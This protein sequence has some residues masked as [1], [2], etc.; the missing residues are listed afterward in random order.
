MICGLL[1]I[2]SNW[3]IAMQSEC[4]NTLS[5]SPLNNSC[6]FIKFIVTS[7]MCAIISTVVLS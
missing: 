6:E 2:L 1:I 4:F 5:S 3:I 7:L